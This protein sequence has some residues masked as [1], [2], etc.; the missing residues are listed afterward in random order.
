MKV[1]DAVIEILRQAGKPL[2]YLEITRKVRASGL[3]ALTGKTP[4]STVRGRIGED[5]RKNQ[6][7]S[8]FV[9][10]GR[11]V[12]SL[13]DGS[14][15][16]EVQNA[17][18]TSGS[19]RENTEVASQAAKTLSFTD[20]AEKVLEECGNGQ[21]MRCADITGIAMRRNWLASRSKNPAGTMSARIG[22]EIKRSKERGEI[23][24]FTSPRRGMFGLSKWRSSGFAGEINRHN[25]KVRQDLLQELRSMPW[26]EFE[27][28]IAEQILEA[29][30]FKRESIV[31]TPY[32]R[33]GGI[34]ARG[35]LEACDNVIQIRMA[36][37]V[38]RR[39]SNQKIQAPV[40]R[41]IRG[42]LETGE[43]GMIITTS[44]FS[45]G[46]RKEA[47]RGSAT[48]IAL[49]NGEELVSHL[50]VNEIGVKK[51]PLEDWIE[52]NKGG[53]SIKEDLDE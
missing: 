45:P 1:R 30:G 51:H 6:K 42:S 19:Q 38:K 37:Q 11:G 14:V 29:L 15:L 53:L 12:Y 50:I 7:N 28:L 39:K 47:V 18:Q 17:P 31:T 44:D 40:V 43:R 4:D 21:P 32:Q 9:R 34:D 22:A 2:H 25:K 10:H 13:A 23:P 33:D 41:D 24:R 48:P 16:P 5:I 46:A 26:Q 36:V 3:C 20:S 52:L 49:M 27:D 35:I 8:P